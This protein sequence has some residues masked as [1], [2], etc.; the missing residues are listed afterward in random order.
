MKRL[1]L[2]SVTVGAL[3]GCAHAL[4]YDTDPFAEARSEAPA[5]ATIVVAADDRAMYGAGWWKNVK[6][7]DKKVGDLR[8]Q[9]YVRANITPGTHVI[10]VAFPPLTM[11]ASPV[12]VQGDFKANMTYYF[13][14]ETRPGGDVTFSRLRPLMPAEGHATLVGKKDR[15]KGV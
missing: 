8:D 6:V 1:L 11:T 13:I 4:P 3:A 10:E 14:W 7:D 15:T 2:I 5:K 9:T 12:S